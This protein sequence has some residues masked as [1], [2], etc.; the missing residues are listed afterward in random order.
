MVLNLLK[1]LGRLLGPIRASEALPGEIWNDDHAW[2][3]DHWS[4]L[5][6][7][8]MDARHYVLEDWSATPP[9]PFEPAV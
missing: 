2:H 3:G 8:P 6:S 5:L 7:S 9:A 4:N 1:Q